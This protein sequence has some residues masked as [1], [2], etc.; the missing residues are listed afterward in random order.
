VRGAPIVVVGGGAPSLTPS[1]KNKPSEPWRQGHG[2]PMQG[3]VAGRWAII[4]Q[5][6]PTELSGTR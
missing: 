4:G 5:V 6:S 3:V 1:G 2:S